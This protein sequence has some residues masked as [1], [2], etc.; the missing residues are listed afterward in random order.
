MLVGVWETVGES[1][2]VDVAVGV[3]V[4]VGVG[5]GG[6]NEANAVDFVTSSKCG[7][8]VQPV[9]GQT[10]DLVQVPSR[11]KSTAPRARIPSIV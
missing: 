10:L 3:G 6:T 7:T 8:V 1:V 5:S 2:G 9:S 4:F 11:T